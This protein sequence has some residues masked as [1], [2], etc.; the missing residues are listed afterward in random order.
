MEKI[1]LGLALHNHQPVGNFPWVFEQ[2]YS[3][4]YL[5]MLKALENHPGIRISLHYS[6]PLLDFLQQKHLDFLSRLT[7]LVQRGQ[8][9]IM[10]GGYYEPILPIIPDEDKLGQIA[11]MNEAI[12]GLFGSKPAG[13]WLAE[14]VWEPGLP[15]IFAQ[16]GIEWTVVDDT[17]FKLVG[18]KDKDLFGYYLTEEQGYPLKIFA[19]SKY[20]RYSVPWRSVAEVVEY[21]RH[22]EQSEATSALTPQPP[23]KIAV[24][25]DDGEKF[26]IWPG[27]YKY[28]WENGWME[29]FFSSLEA[30]QE[31]LT[32]IPLG[33]YARQF[34]PLGRIYLPCASYDEMLEWA[35]PP[36]KSAQ[37][38][39][40]KHELEK[41]S[42]CEPEV[43]KTQDLVQFLRGG[44]WRHFLVKYPEANQMHKK[45]L[46]VH[47]KVYAA[48]ELISSRP[49]APQAQPPLY[50][51]DRDEERCGLAD[52]WRGQ[53]NCPYWHG[54]FGGLYL[55][56]IRAATYHHLIQAEN[57]ADAII[58]PEQPWLEWEKVDF[59]MDGRKEIL[60]NGTF[61]SL[62][63]SPQQGG[64]LLEWDLR[65][66][67]Y[68]LLSTVA[69]R[70][71]PYHQTLS[72]ASAKTADTDAQIH[73]IHEGTR[74]K[75]SETLR[76]LS[77]DRYPRYSLMEHF[78]SPHVTLEQFVSC[79]YEELGG[80][81]SQPYQAGVKRRGGSLRIILRRSD[82]LHCDGEFLPF[83]VEKEIIMG[84]AKEELQ[85]NYRL[86][87]KSHA[88]A[89]GI[90]SSEW[91]I[92]LLGGGHNEQAYYK[93][94]GVILDDY[95]L[96]SSGALSEVREVSLA[97]KY[98]GIK[99]SL[100][101]EPPITLWRFPVET[102]SNSE[103]GLERSY[104]GSCL[105]LLL[106]FKLPPG[107][108]RVLKLRWAAAE[109][110]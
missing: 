48:L 103:A 44:Y 60:V 38:V 51:L 18:L 93:V 69:R 53:C 16:A 96:D 90:F 22:C 12:A 80:F 75:D 41:E 58:H 77:Y 73:S 2:A 101:V 65:R 42:H 1:Y 106:P 55:A 74:V 36:D 72:R 9:E 62:Y 40:I 23:A 79:A 3:Q 47:K 8:V 97:N 37:L 78:L 87:N 29:E 88:L 61:Y 89:S 102:I 108:D 34:P 30:N 110:R 70:P 5:P 71:E 28:C 104:Q 46:Q 49:R 105:L 20:L 94:P 83:E 109:G 59:D 86:S 56:D 57:K 81:A 66:P 17:H 15:K 52:L 50:L 14:R 45:M 54:V 33:E 64:S 92:N 98:L 13:L 67:A 4:A 21:L 26:G 82:K 76:L 68:N 84:Q 95:H 85:V 6:G 24:M 10:T 32:T 7:A 19:S 35:L 63:F 39:N 91:N 31:W 43:K 100:S 27:T 25:G 107:V 11:K 99:V